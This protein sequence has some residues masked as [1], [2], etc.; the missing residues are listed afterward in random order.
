MSGGHFEYDCFKIA[1][2]AEALQEEID[3]NEKKDEDGYVANISPDC[4]ALIQ[5]SQRII[6]TAGKLAKTIEWR[7]SGDTA[8]DTCMSEIGEILGGVK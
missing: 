2:F 7:Y 1:N 8:D 6:E 4:L 3:D 5:M